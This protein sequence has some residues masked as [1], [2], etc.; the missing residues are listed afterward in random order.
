VKVSSEGFEDSYVKTDINQT[1][2]I[3][4]LDK[5]YELDLQIL[6]DGEFYSGNA[7]INF[8]GT[9]STFSFAY[10]EQNKVV[11][12]EG[13][14]EIEAYLY[15]ESSLVF[16]ETTTEYCVD[17]PSSGIKGY[18]GLQEEE[19][20]E[21]VIPEQ[22]IENV[23]IGGGKIEYYFL[24]KD[25]ENSQSLILNTKGLSVPESIDELAMNHELVERQSLEVEFE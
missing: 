13:E 23:L 3:F 9:D 17:V 12:S 19:C 5:E 20:F 6:S 10:P 16:E 11:L 1:E 8:I 15:S 22:E 4:I 24:E 18:F 14:Y 25:L 2:V 7:I 21:S